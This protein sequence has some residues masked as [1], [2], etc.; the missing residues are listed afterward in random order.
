MDEETLTV[1]SL[2]VFCF[3]HVQQSLQRVFLDYAKFP[4]RYFTLVIIRAS[5]RRALKFQIPATLRE[6]S[7]FSRSF[8]SL[9][10]HHFGRMQLRSYANDQLYFLDP[11]FSRIQDKR[12]KGNLYIHNARPRRYAHRRYPRPEYSPPHIRKTLTDIGAR[13]IH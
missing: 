5:S 10:Y 4:S 8:N 9:L 13:R 3:R 1:W 6:S 11:L 2:T 12:F 7:A